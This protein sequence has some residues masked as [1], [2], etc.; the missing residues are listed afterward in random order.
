MKKIFNNADKAK[1]YIIK[2][3]M[4]NFSD[5]TFKIF[6]V[7]IIISWGLTKLVYPY[8]SFSVKNMILHFIY[9]FI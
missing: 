7:L 2:E 8:D 3:I 9:C 6:N 1:E 4:S 5:G